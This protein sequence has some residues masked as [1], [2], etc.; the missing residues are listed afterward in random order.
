[1]QVTL[2]FLSARLALVV[3][4]TVLHKKEAADVHI[5]DPILGPDQGPILVLDTERNILGRE[6]VPIHPILREEEGGITEEDMAADLH[7]LTERGTRETEYVCVR[8][9]ES[10]G[11]VCVCVCVCVRER[12][13]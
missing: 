7:C 13:R 12:E 8:E 10:G 4:V 5:P 2:P 6:A 11:G 9:R 3:S 1:M